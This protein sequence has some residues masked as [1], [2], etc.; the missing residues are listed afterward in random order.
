M[1]AIRA[2]RQVASS[3]CRGL[4]ARQLSGRALPI[5]AARIS[6]TAP[7]S[8][9]AFSVSARRFGQGTSKFQL[10]LVCRFKVEYVCLVF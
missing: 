8:S 3:S 9:R 6:V 2:L 1:S 4:A 7:V 5:L 10:F